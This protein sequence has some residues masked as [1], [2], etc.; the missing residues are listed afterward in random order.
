MFEQLKQVRAPGAW[1]VELP[2]AREAVGKPSS[3]TGSG[4]ATPVTSRG[5]WNSVEH[6]FTVEN[7]KR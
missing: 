2:P 7:W 4:L 6:R 1:V 3:R 5:Q